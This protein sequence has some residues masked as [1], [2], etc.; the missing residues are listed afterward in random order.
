MVGFFGTVPTILMSKTDLYIEPAYFAEK[1]NPFIW[2]HN[3]NETIDNGALVIGTDINTANN[4]SVFL[5]D[6]YRCIYIMVNKKNK[7]H[8]TSILSDNL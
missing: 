2:S 4:N 8:I 1:S 6:L 5:S 3:S 7:T